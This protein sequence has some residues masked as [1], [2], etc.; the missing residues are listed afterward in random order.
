MLSI[1][2][3]LTAS[4][5]RAP[6]RDFAITKIA[7]TS[8]AEAVGNVSPFLRCPVFGG[9]RASTTVGTVGGARVSPSQRRERMLPFWGDFRPTRITSGP[10]AV[11]G[12]RSRL[13]RSRDYRASRP[14]R[15]R[16]PLS[17]SCL[18]DAKTHR[19]TDRAFYIN[20]PTIIDNGL[21]DGGQ[22]RLPPLSPYNYNTPEAHAHTHTTDFLSALSSILLETS[23]GFT[24]G[25]FSGL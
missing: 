9:R 11:S 23:S 12:S 13:L 19:R 1:R 15:E 22:P 18:V 24:T 2:A 14:R 8:G 3:G 10:P 17:R 21:T 5:L 7:A 6:P 4:V 16:G 25:H 20:Y